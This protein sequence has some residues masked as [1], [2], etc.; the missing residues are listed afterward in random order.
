MIREQR[1][2]RLRVHTEMGSFHAIT[3]IIYLRTEQH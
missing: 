2:A 3:R 1:T